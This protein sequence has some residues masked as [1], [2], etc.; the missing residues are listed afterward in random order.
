M[1]PFVGIRAANGIYVR[2]E[3]ASELPRRETTLRVGLTAAPA[4][5]FPRVRTGSAVYARR[6]KMEVHH[7][8]LTRSVTDV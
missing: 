6:T 5:R 8:N 1:T 2:L 4:A 7:T 3:R